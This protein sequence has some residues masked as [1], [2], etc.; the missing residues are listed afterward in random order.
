MVLLSTF[1]GLLGHLRYNGLQ[2]L[3][4]MTQ[5]HACCD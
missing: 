3:S 5:T 1:I 4:N 2:H